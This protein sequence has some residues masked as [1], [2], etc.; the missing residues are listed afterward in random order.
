MAYQI[1]E[2]MDEVDEYED[3][4]VEES[5]AVVQGGVKHTKYRGIVQQQGT[6]QNATNFNN[7]EGGIFDAHTAM[8]LMVNAHRQSQWRIEALEKATAQETGEVTLNNTLEFPFNDSQV[9][10]PL[11]VRRDNLN[12]VVEVISVTPTGGPSGEIEVSDRQVNGFKM[13]FTGSATKCVVKYAVI[14]GFD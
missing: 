5:S 9:S 4:F 14:G 10:I 7:M 8:D 12:Y 2:W 6:P 1:T 11:T 13:A 3:I